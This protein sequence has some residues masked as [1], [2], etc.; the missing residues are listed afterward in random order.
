MIGSDDRHV[1]CP[2]SPQG[3]EAEKI[4]GCDVKQIWTELS[5]DL[6]GFPGDTEGNPVIGAARSLYGLDRYE[7]PRMREGRHWYGGSKNPHVGAI[8]AQKIDKPVEREGDS[9]SYMVVGACKKRDAQ[10]QNSHIIR[11]GYHTAD[12]D[13]IPSLAKAEAKSI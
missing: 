4:G 3:G 9:I 10:I 13:L 11:L 2:G 6:T 1:S 5:K 12:P 8:P 7:R